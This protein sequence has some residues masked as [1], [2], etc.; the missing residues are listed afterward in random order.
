[1]NALTKLAVALLC[2]GLLLGGAASAAQ[3]HA[4]SGWG[5]A[6]GAYNSSQHRLAALDL[7]PDGYGVRVFYKFSTNGQVYN[8]DNDRGFTQVTAR[9]LGNVS[10]NVGIW[11]CIKRG[12]V[13]REC[14]PAVRWSAR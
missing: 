5:G 7:Q 8:L 1:M 12:A 4:A 13:T 6:L 3:A 14:D 9:D 2:A 10:G 11:A